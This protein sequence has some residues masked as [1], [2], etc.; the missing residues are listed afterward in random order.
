MGDETHASARLPLLPLH[1][2]HL[3]SLRVFHFLSVHPQVVLPL[4]LLHVPLLHPVHVAPNS[5]VSGGFLLVQKVT[6]CNLEF[7]VIDSCPTGKRGTIVVLVSTSS[8]DLRPVSEVEAGI[9]F[10]PVGSERVQAATRT[11]H[12]VAQ[13]CG[14][15]FHQPGGS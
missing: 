12:Q 13:V 4:L 9:N 1:L 2:L 11:K 7:A 15:T 8:E 6:C 5:V 3:L 14:D 10:R